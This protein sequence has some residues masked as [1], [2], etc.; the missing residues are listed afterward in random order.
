MATQTHNATHPSAFAGSPLAPVVIGVVGLGLLTWLGSPVLRHFEGAAIPWP[1]HGLALALLLSA[2]RVHRNLTAVLV[3]LSA[4]LGAVFEGATAPRALGAAALLVG[5]TLVVVELYD[6]LTAGRHPL[7]GTIAYSRFL[8]ASVVGVL[9]TTIIAHLTVSIVGPDYVPGW[10]IGHWLI[11][12]MTS[13]IALTPVLLVVNAP[14]QPAGAL[15]SLVSLE[16]F[17][18]CAAYAAVLLNA[19]L[20]LGQFWIAIP[21]AVATLPFLMWA[22][23]R[24]GVRGFCIAAVLFIAAVVTSAVINVG[25]FNI[26]GATVPERGRRA[27]IYLASL[28][29]PSMLFPIAL[30][31]HRVAESRIRGTLAQ[32]AAIIEGSGDLIAAVDRD[33]TIIAVNSAWVDEFERLSGRRVR[34]G[35]RMADALAPL[36]GDAADSLAHWRRALNGERFTV[37]REIGEVAR[38]RSDYE[39]TYGPVRDEQ[40]VVVG[41]SQVVRNISERRR[42][43]AEDADA[44]RLESVGRLAGGVA[45][46]FNNLMTAVIGYTEI[47]QQSLPSG[48]PRQDDLRQ[49]EKAASRAG[50]LT[51]Q[52][53]AFARRRMIEPR[54]VDLAE[55]VD[56]LTGLLRPLLGSGVQLAVRTDPTLPTVRLDPTQFEQVLMNLAVNARD[57]MPGGGKLSIE[58]TND[59]RGEQRGVR[60]AVRDSGTG[61]TPDV[62]KRLWEPFFTTKP[63]GKGTGLGLP[64][65]HG[66]VHQAGGDITVDSV[67]GRGTTFIVFLPAAEA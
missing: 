46:D 55:L 35:I 17:L 33:L 41:A 36:P 2:Q 60:L 61:M 24:F 65:V 37:I 19:F 67:V 31:E 51:Q 8:A 30:T 7:R 48:D 16:F 45:H 52:L 4:T 59:L 25:P 63:L 9:P 15:R 47:L 6:R 49:I 5:Q 14:P 12:A 43:E 42:R 26:F 62:L 38:L 66:I 39:I 53:L 1:A 27:W 23:F 13:I 18:L 44:R 29:G 3:L 58:L 32:L 20:H 56:G 21:P 54:L 50:E 64:T 40:G 57:A 28:V 10:N 11:A 22:G 34:A